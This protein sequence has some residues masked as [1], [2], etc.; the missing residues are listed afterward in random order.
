MFSWSFKWLWAQCLLASAG[1]F[2]LGWMAVPAAKDLT[3]IA[4]Q[5]EQVNVISRKGLGSFYELT[6]TTPGGEQDRVLIDHDGV[7]N[8]AMH[9]LIGHRIV[10]EINWSSEA[11]DFET[12]DPSTSI[13]KNVRSTALG[14]Q[15]TFDALGIAALALGIFLGLAA[16][17]LSPRC[18]RDQ[19]R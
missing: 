4:G 15:Q 6:V 13:A 19:S 3:Q 1:L 17:I 16:L 9:A 14:S 2:L 11:V 7:R 8:E 5:V 10:A 18:A 12:D